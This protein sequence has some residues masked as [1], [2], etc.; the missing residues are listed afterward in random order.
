MPSL[1]QTTLK[2]DSSGTRLPTRR[3]VR[4]AFVGSEHEWVVMAP[5][6]RDAAFVERNS[7][8]ITRSFPVRKDYDEDSTKCGCTGRCNSL[9]AREKRGCINVLSCT[10]CDDSNCSVG[11]T[12]GNRFMP[13]YALNLFESAVGVG[14]VTEEF[15]PSGAFVVEYVGELLYGEDAVQR[16][17]KRYLAELRTPTV[18]DEVLYIDA[19]RCGNA[20]RLINHSCAPNCYMEEWNWANT[21]RLGIFA[22]RDLRPLTELTFAYGDGGTARFACRCNALNCR[23]LQP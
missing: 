1:R 17:D 9:G 11:G 15:I 10:V 3:P 4:A 19:R 5:W 6:P 18:N 7:F 22:S 8:D 12:C 2:F 16:D 21:V 14:V 20:S 13:Q 23:A